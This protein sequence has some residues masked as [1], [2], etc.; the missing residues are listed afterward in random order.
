MVFKVTLQPTGHTYSANSGVPVLEAGLSAGFTMPYSCRAGNCKTC[1]GRIVQ[2]EVDHGSAH[3]AYL[4]E[5]Q[6]A[7]GFALLCCAKPRSDLVIEVEELVMQSIVPKLMPCRIKRMHKPVA[8]VA[9][10]ELRLPMNENL[11][12]AAGQYI[13]FQLSDG[14]TRSYSIAS[15]PTAEGVIDLELHIRHSP[16]GVFTDPLFSTTKQGEL[17]RLRAPLGT[18]YLREES[19]KPIVFMATGTG[20]A[21]VKSMIS[22]ALRKGIKRPMAL[23]WERERADLY[24]HELV[25]DWASENLIKY[26]PVLSRPRQEDQWMGRTGYVQH[27]VMQDYPDLSGYQVYAC[28]SPAMVDAAG[29]EMVLK[30]HLAESDFFADSFVTER[31]RSQVETA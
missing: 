6:K 18:F 30:N 22:Y 1:R 11:M 23:Y 16:G 31:E 19:D 24:M 15:A 20:F 5:Q 21:P 28:G 10:V 17:L 12:F 8:D 7:D 14:K 29:N 4:T 26:V 13:D 9:V 3:G 27:A 2:G 25:Q